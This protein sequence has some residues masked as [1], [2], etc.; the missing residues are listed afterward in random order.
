MKYITTA[1]TKYKTLP[2]VVKA[3]FWFLLCSFLQ[4]GIA[5]ISTPIFTRLMTP[6]EFGSYSVFNSWLTILSV[7]FTLNLFGGVY[8]QGLVKFIDKQAKFSSA[9]QGLT[10]TLVI[11]WFLIYLYFSDYCNTLL[12]IN[13]TQ[14]CCM[15]LLIWLSA[16]FC[17]WSAQQRVLNK[18]ISL[19]VVSFTFSLLSTLLGIVFVVVSEDKVTSR[20]LSLVIMQ[21]ALYSVLFVSQ[22]YRG[23]CFFDWKIWK[24]VLLFNIPLLPHYLSSALL[25]TIDKIMIEKM[26]GVA[27]SGLYSLAFSIGFLMTLFNSALLQSVEPWLYKRIKAKNFLGVANFANILLIF[28]AGVNIL[29]IATAPELIRLFAPIEYYESIWVIPPIAMGSFFTFA[30][31]LFVAFEFYYEKTRLIA[32]ATIVGALIKVTLNF[33]LLGNLGYYVAGYTT[34]LCFMILA[35]MHFCFM[36][37][38]CKENLKDQR[39]YDTRSLFLITIAFLIIGFIF[40]ASYLEPTVRYVLILILIIILFALHKK[41]TNTIRGVLLL[42]AE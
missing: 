1:F 21:V 26:I 25:N 30:Y 16:V 40:L 38:V 10:L 6:A 7:I 8:I 31:S 4:K 29:L 11:F 23:K 9:L 19:I 33:L 28:I 27:E 13:T 36:Q 17:F 32:L 2:T 18:Y 20:I 12:S 34:L 37:Y 42:R 39:I 22:M 35:G 5:I 3:S 24:Y 41:I 15:F 14:V